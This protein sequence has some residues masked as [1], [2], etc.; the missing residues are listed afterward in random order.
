[1][2]KD[3]L[4]T[5]AARAEAAAGADRELDAE[6]VALV[7][8]AADGQPGDGDWDWFYAERGEPPQ[9]VPAFTASRDAAAS[10]LPEHWV[11]RIETGACS[12]WV[13]ATKGQ[14]YAVE[15]KAETEARARTAV[16]LRAMAEEIN[17]ASNR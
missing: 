3:D 1:M 12:T 14:Q 11:C 4:L 16:A 13:R 15:A 10:L 8:G 5:L 2:N 9:C 6:I 7:P 17:N